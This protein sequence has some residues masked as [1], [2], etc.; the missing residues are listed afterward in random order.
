MFPFHRSTTFVVGLTAAGLALSASALPVSAAASPVPASYFGVHDSTVAAPGR[1]GWP[2]TPVGSLRLWDTGT[3]WRDI[4]PTATGGWNVT[5]LDQQVATAIAHRTQP[6]IVLGGTP[7][8]ASAMPRDPKNKRAAFL[9]ADGSA[10]PQKAA[11]QKYVSFVVARYAKRGVHNFQ[12]WNEPN[13]SG[14]W[15]GT[16]GQAATVA[17]WAIPLIRRYDPRA[18][19]ISPSFV[20]RLPD[21]QRKFIAFAATGL[22]RRVDV[23]ALQLYPLANQAPE[24]SVALVTGR[25]RVAPSPYVFPGARAVLAKYRVAKPIW[26]TE[27]NYGL[28]GGGRARRVL[29]S[30]LSAAYVAR[31]YLLSKPAGISRVYWYSWSNSANLFGINMTAADNATLTAAARAFATT[32]RWMAG[33][34]LQSCTHDAAQ[35]YHCVLVTRTTIGHVYWNATAKRPVVRA[36]AR[37]YQFE[38]VGGGVSKAKAG[39]TLKVGQAPVVIRVKR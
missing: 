9:G 37:T 22:L 2:A 30:A 32:K 17:D 34:V 4:Q 26:D 15:A 33:Q 27:V 7:S 39:S 12:L 23:V 6:V 38:Y 24:N 11:W 1:A 29:P 5:R 3:T 28:A 16:P 20:L 36:P 19:V 10:V 21:A 18:T 35:T 8:W 25:T 13:V 31:T 14:F